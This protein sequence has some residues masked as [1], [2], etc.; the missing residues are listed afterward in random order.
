[1]RE[2]VPDLNLRLPLIHASLVPMKYRDFELNLCE[3]IRDKVIG[4]CVE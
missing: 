2:V 3:D 4:W 1:M